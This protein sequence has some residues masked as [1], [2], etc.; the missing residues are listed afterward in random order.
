MA[1]KARNRFVCL[2]LVGVGSLSL[3]APTLATDL[4]ALIQSSCIECHDA[5]TE[6]HLDFTAL[7][8]DF[9]SAESFRKW[10]HVFDRIKSGEMPP[11][12]ETQPSKTA[13]AKA[14]AFL[15]N[16]L[17]PMSPCHPKEM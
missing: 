2:L 4:D 14:L 7:G 9:E 10:V 16:E 1:Q 12:G 6:T 5:D 8:R 15:G 17:K 3:C 13:R 11:P